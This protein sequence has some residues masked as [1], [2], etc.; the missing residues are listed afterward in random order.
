MTVLL[1]GRSDPSRRF[2]ETYG[3]KVRIVFK[4]FP[5]PNHAQ[6]FKALK[7]RTAPGD[8]GKYWEMH[9]RCSP[10]SER[11]KCPPSKTR[12]RPWA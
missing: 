12:P 2:C 6:A 11:W 4:D 3:N 7:R 8:Q 9:D 1:E 5:L 10:T